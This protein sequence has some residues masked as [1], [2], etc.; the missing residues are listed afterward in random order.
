MSSRNDNLEMTISKWQSR[1]GD[2][3][4]AI[5]KWRSRNGNLEMASR[6]CISKLRG[7]DLH[8][9]F[10]NVPFQNGYRLNAIAQNHLEIARG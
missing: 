5:S 9:L 6:N 10:Y 8:T 2:L 3:E 4:M 7:G 1:N